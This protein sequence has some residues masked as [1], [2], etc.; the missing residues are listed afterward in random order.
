MCHPL[1]RYC[2]LTDI[3]RLAVSLD[4]GPYPWPLEVRQNSIFAIKWPPIIDS[5]VNRMMP[6][7]YVW[8]MTTW[9]TSGS[10]YIVPTD[11]S[12]HD[13]SVGSSTCACFN[14]SVVTAPNSVLGC[15]FKD[16]TGARFVPAR[17]T[18]AEAS[19]SV[20]SM[21][22]SVVSS[23]FSIGLSTLLSHKVLPVLALS[24]KCPRTGSRA[25]SKFPMILSKRGACMH[26][27]F[28]SPEK[29]EDFSWIWAVSYSLL[30][31]S[32]NV[33]LCVSPVS[34]SALTTACLTTAVKH[35]VSR[36]TVFL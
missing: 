5:C 30:D 16:F 12:Q 23:G 6:A 1:L 29:Y 26:M 2:T 20:V 4:I 19:A 3:R 10:L 35:P 32:T 28:T 31:P 11:D 24:L 22:T 33:H 36:S 9:R 7:L 17:V 25:P 21:E 13:F 18:T 8:G 14:T 27:A 15:T 34:C